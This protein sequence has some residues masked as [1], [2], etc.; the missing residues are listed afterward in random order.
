MNKRIRILRIVLIWIVVSVLSLPVFSQEEIIVRNDMY[1]HQVHI[2][3]GVPLYVVEGFAPVS[4][5]EVGIP[6]RTLRFPIDEHA[7]FDLRLENVEYSPPVTASPFYR[8]TLSLAPDSAILTTPHPV[9]PLSHDG[10]AVAGIRSR[11]YTRE[12]GRLE[13]VITV[14]LLVWDAVANETRWIE[15]YRFTAVPVEGISAV[16]PASEGRPPYSSQPFTQR[17]KNVDTSQAWIDFDTPMLR[18]FVRQDGLYKITADWLR[19]AGIDP[20]TVDPSRVQLYRKG[21]PI[22]MYIHGTEDGRFDDDDYMLFQGTRNYTEGGHKRLADNVEDPYPEYISIYTDSTAYWLNFSTPSPARALPFE[23]SGINP[24]DTLDW[25]YKH[26]HVERNTYLNFVGSSLVRGQMPH[27][28][29]EKTWVIGGLNINRT[30]REAVPVNN[31]KED[32]IAHYWAKSMSWF[33]NTAVYPNHSLTLHVNDSPTLDSATF[34]VDEQALLHARFPAGYLY[35]GIDTLKLSSHDVQGGY[36]HVV[37]DWYELDYPRY[38]FAESDRLLF[39]IDTLM[40]L[41]MRAIVLRAFD[42]DDV[43]GVV[44]EGSVGRLLRPVRREG[45]GPYDFVFVDTVR[46]GA[47]YMFTTEAEMLRPALGEAI[48]PKR[49]VTSAEQAGYIIVTTG[50]LMQASREYADFIEAEYN[51]TTMLFDI[52]DIYNTY[53]YGMFQPEAIKLLLFDARNLWTTD[54]LRYVFLIGDANY[55][56]TWSTAEFARN[57]VPSYG[58]PVSDIWYVCYDPSQTRP[59]IPIGR[60]SARTG[61]E[62]LSYRDKH[63][64]YLRHPY[65]LWNKSTIHFSGGNLNLGEIE[66]LKYKGINQQVINSLVTPLPFSGQATHFFKTVEPQTDFGPYSDSF[67]QQRIDEGAVFISYIGH[68]GTQT[69]DNSVSTPE[70]IQNNRG[71]SSLV[72]D[73]GCST[74]R[75]AEPDIESF[76]EMCVVREGGQFIGYIGNSSAGFESTTATLP[77]LYYSALIRDRAPTLGQALL[78]SKYRLQDLYGA[79]L[80]NIVATYTNLLVG[81]PI[82]R[83]AL[84]EKSNLVVR[85]QWMRTENDIITD[86]MDSVSFSLVYAN[87]GNSVPDSVEIVLEHLVAGNVTHS[88]SLRRP[89]PAIYD[90]IR[91]VM[92]VPGVA[93]V[94]A[95]RVV[96]DP[97]NR[98]DE[99][100]EN[101]NTATLSYQVLSTFL[102][103]VDTRLGTARGVQ[104]TIRV[105]NPVFDQ[106]EV[107]SVAFEFDTTDAFANVTSRSAA[108]GKTISSLGDIPSLGDARTLYWRARLD[109]GAAE[110]A[111]PYKLHQHIEGDFVQAD[112]ADFL[113]STFDDSRWA[114]DAVTLLPA[115]RTLQIESSG[116]NTGVFAAIRLNGLNLL[117]STL[118]K[119][120]HIAIFDSLTMKVLSV[121]QYN[122]ID[123]G[124]HRDS[125]RIMVESIQPGQIIAVTTSD[126]P[127]SG[128]NVFANA[129]R[130]I[131]SVYIDSVMQRGT[132]GSWGIISHFGAAAGSVPE[133]F[134]RADQYERVILDQI[135]TVPPDKGRMYSPRIGPAAA[136]QEVRLGRSDPALSDIR[137]SVHG[138][139]T[140]GLR[141][142]LLEAENVSTV[143]LASIDA[144]RWRY[145]EL[146]A[147]LLPEGHVMPFIGHWAVSYVQA[148]ELAINYQSVSMVS[149][150]VQQGFPAELHVGILNAGE[151]AATNVPVLVEVVGQDNLPR[152][153]SSFAIDVLHG[154]A[155]FDT[156]IAFSTDA[157]TG[158]YQL[159]VFVD[160]DNVIFEQY[161]DNNTYLS[162]MF[163]RADT[164]KPRMEI[165]FDGFMPLDGDF[166]RYNPEIVLRLHAPPPYP[167]L[168]ME[169]FTVTLDGDELGLD[170]LGASFTPS[171]KS[172][173]AV[174]R[175]QPNLPDGEY[176]F[177][178]NATDGNRQRVYEQDLEI[179]V[180]VSTQSRISELYNY[181]NPFTD[182]T[183]FTFLLTGQEAPEEVQVKVYT[184]AGRLIR[185]LY[186]PRTSLRIGYNALKWDGR[187]Q[188]GDV[189]ANGVYFYKIISKFSD[190]TI[191]DIGR[192]A[193]MR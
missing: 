151:A 25:A 96:L 45:S 158:P 154:R 42:G 157:F 181:P 4:D 39:S 67:V 75:F 52:D 142:T 192:M 109:G 31:L 23:A 47:T 108:Y 7:H 175:F 136:W 73:F 95:L 35:N 17:S 131:G 187:D 177:G 14:P 133:G 98:I 78:A 141:E 102:K 36:S 70:Q 167:V 64:A 103:V 147:T 146:E 91:V 127:R 58:N 163:V 1:L 85:E 79:H 148:S 171:T 68:S 106:G 116:W 193:V 3:D 137:V 92:P 155:W 180:R 93:G 140:A 32:G 21:V 15:R 159:R 80:I 176:Y 46:Y 8:M 48:I 69:W 99:I 10:H 132:R 60:L 124:H 100:Y 183:S 172:S 135:Y 128:S 83:L 104:D 107:A 190:T 71:R 90:T 153:V 119:G 122:N 179:R 134:R 19:E 54:S 182:E 191:E 184:V 186:Y 126:E 40:G 30:A 59:S 33:G 117:K 11:H 185:T 129:M 76:A 121:A 130:A 162:S 72:T 164:T 105:L 84:P 44:Q 143:S 156:T 118:D 97:E 62:I 111:G 120:Y 27:W 101:D 166:I 139:D 115:T 50:E 34:G 174:L 123:V 138:I 24:A 114:D 165:A 22:P 161:E 57:Y 43:Y 37:V 160:R 56:Y 94:S 86:V 55:H 2:I 110:Y 152:T 38:L 145:I 125:I 144:N 6:Y 150:T 89:V 26:V 53:S 12:N 16:I 9:A 112:S 20:G 13:L 173:P 87:Y 81:D 28:T 18:F 170:S 61:A 178:F 149:D 63:E 49:L 51:I 189:I 77:L 168:S 74:A 188:D 82:V 41:G 5:S 88:L 65:D 66:V 113:S 29:S 169:N